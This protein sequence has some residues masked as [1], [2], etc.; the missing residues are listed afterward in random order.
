MSR[1]DQKMDEKVS[2]KLGVVICATKLDR[3]ELECS[4][5]TAMR[6]KIRKNTINFVKKFVITSIGVSLL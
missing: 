6:S 4:L 1:D 2:S 3:V 5:K